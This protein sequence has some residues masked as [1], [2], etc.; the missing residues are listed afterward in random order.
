MYF[1]IDTDYDFFLP[2]LFV[3]FLS[4][5][6]AQ[7]VDVTTVYDPVAKPAELAGQSVVT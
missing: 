6:S 7:S 2:S 3:F 4:H 5:L 1:S